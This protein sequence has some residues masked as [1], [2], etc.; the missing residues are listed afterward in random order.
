MSGKKIF[1]VVSTGD[2]LSGGVSS[3][4]H[5]CKALIDNGFNSEMYYVR[6]NEDLIQ[7]KFQPRFKVPRCNEIVDNENNVIIV[8]EI[9]PFIFEDY[10]KSARI[11]Y[12]LSLQFFFRNGF[13][14]QWPMNIKLVRK[15]F[16]LKDFNALKPGL[17]GTFKQKILFKA[18]SGSNAW[19][20]E[21]I[22]LTNSF[23]TA[24]F[25]KRM[26]VEKVNIIYNPILEEIFSVP[27]REKKNQILVGAKTSKLLIFLLKKYCSG[28]RIIVLKGL[29]LSRVYELM[30]ESLIFAEFGISNRDR[31]P[32]EAAILGCIVFTSNSGSAF[33]NED[34]PIPA[35]YKINQHVFNFIKIVRRILHS[36]TNYEIMKHDF[37]PYRKL[38]TDEANTFTL[39]VGNLFLEILVK[40]FNRF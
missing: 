2:V 4:H 1:Y 26:G 25:C 29:P 10:P 22:H 31:T 14:Y 38:I 16:Y 19:N 3:L 37:E 7:Q 21:I 40:G 33:Y 32:R 23:Y 17:I 20:P 24:T 18:V 15:L 35:F 34:V 36:A 8:P 13:A 6:A 39:R 28:F 11:V 27:K 12:W 9:L 5:L 30:A